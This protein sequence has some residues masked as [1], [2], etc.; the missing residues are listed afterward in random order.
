MR[1]WSGIRKITSLSFSILVPPSTVTTRDSLSTDRRRCMPSSDTIKSL[2]HAISEGL[3]PLPTT[4]I[5]TSQ[6]SL[7]SQQSKPCLHAHSPVSQR[8]RHLGYMTVQSSA[9]DDTTRSRDVSSSSPWQVA[10]PGP[11]G[12]L[13]VRR[14]CPLTCVQSDIC[15]RWLSR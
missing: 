15:S 4:R 6:P 10:Y 11:I 9:G 12:P 1:E 8:H 7:C 14:H 3:C 2:V 5:C 13:P